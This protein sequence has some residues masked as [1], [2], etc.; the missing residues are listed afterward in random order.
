M[1]AM[2]HFLCILTFTLLACGAQ[3]VSQTQNEADQKSD[4]K[5]EAPEW[6][7]DKW[8]YEVN[9][10]QFT[11]EG[12]F[13]AFERHLPRLKQMGI[14]I[15]WL[16]PIHP[17]GEEKRKGSL[18]SYYSIKD[19]KGINPEFGTKEDFKNLIEKV[20]AL[21]MYIMI[22]WV[23]NH[24][25]FD[26]NLATEHPEWYTREKGKM[27]PPVADWSDVADLNYEKK[28]LHTYMIEA[29]E[30]W[31]REFDIDGYRCDV[32]G[33]VPLKF[34]QR[35]NKSLQAIKPVFMLAEAE[36]ANLH[37]GAFHM[38]YAWSLHHA[39]NKVARGEAKPAEL[40]A[41]IDEQ[42]KKFPKDAILLNFTSNHDENS[43]NGTTKERMGDADQGFAR[44]VNF[45]PVVPLI[46]SGQEAPLEKRL[47]FFEKDAI[48]WGSFAYVPLYKE[49]TKVRK[50]NSALWT[51][52]SSGTL[53]W[54]ES[55]HEAVLSFWRK[56]DE[57]EI[58]FIFNLS[59]EFVTTK[60][61]I[62]D[63]VGAFSNIMKRENRS[64][65]NAQ[66]WRLKPWDFVAY[67]KSN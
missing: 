61:D 10:R 19:Y 45:F 25:A 51:G 12:T 15:L 49:L 50:E 36:E 17:I 31:V 55:D 65:H 6:V 32:A 42:L 22:D 39:M 18:G 43:W 5:H 26:C 28:G 44:L 56:N 47:E 54:V 13:K 66:N 9:I 57:Q 63:A 48:D 20:H 53:E 14:D 33:M 16:M 34:W 21:D 41:I 4:F 38:S 64:I 29:M 27:V 37:E 35:A 24:S 60:V 3:K 11:E 30:Y 7:K 67:R 62:G 52:E 40:K 59:A 23:A 1:K 8:L 58:L 46:Y 2:K